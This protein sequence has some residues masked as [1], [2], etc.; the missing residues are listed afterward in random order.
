MS[1]TVMSRESN[2]L[3]GTSRAEAISA[4]EG[5]FLTEE[6]RNRLS[7][8]ESEKLSTQQQRAEILSFYKQLAS[9]S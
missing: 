7:A 1:D 9:A 2:S 4:I 5:Q 8:W 6:Q 3:L